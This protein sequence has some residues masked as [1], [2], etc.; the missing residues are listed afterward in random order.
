ML[1]PARE[2]GV[3]I[4]S[5]RTRGPIR[6]IRVLIVSTRS[7]GPTSEIGVLML[8]TRTRGPTNE[9]G[10]LML[11]TDAGSIR[12]MRTC[13]GYEWTVCLVVELQGPIFAHAVIA[14]SR[15]VGSKPMCHHVVC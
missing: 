1:G 4:V 13:K 6:E 9:I 12:I 2:I 10:V 8:S 3:P 14:N 5:I 15:N 7:R 11:N